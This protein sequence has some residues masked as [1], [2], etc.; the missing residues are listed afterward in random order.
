VAL[1]CTVKGEA[2]MNSAAASAGSQE[3]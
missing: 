1:N 2:A 3:R